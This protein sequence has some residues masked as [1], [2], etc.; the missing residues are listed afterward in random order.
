MYIF[1]RYVRNAFKSAYL[2]THNPSV[3]VGLHNYSQI[4]TFKGVGVDI[5]I[6]GVK[7][8]L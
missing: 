6:V 3:G 5:K 4:R 2:T 1:Q 7:S 8:R